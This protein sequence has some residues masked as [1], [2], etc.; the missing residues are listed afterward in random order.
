MRVFRAI[1]CNFQWWAP[2]KES[3]FDAF[4]RVKPDL[5]LGCTYSVD[6]AVAKCIARRPEMKVA[7]FASAWGEYLKDVD[8][9]K[10]PLVVTGEQEKRVVDEL[11]RTTGKPDC[12]FIHAH[13]RWLDGTMGGW[14]SLGIPYLGLLNAADVFVYLGGRKRPELACDAAF[15]GA[16]WGYKSRNIDRFL[17]PLCHLNSGLSVRIY[18]RGGWDGIANWLGP[19]SDQTASDLFASATVCPSVSEP[20]ST[21]LGWDLIERPLKTSLCGFSVSDHVEEG[22][23]LF[24]AD[25]LPMARTPEEMRDL[26]QHFAARPDD[27]LPFMVKMRKKVLSLHTYHHRVSVLLTALG[28]FDEAEAAMDNLREVL[29]E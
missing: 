10:Y 13:G 3:A 23:D 17:L 28:M 27:R 24:G 12:V 29:G 1:G 19:C 4:S 2:E 11:R 20:H 15:V 18:G 22:R 9:Q 8:L 14:G 25:E 7:L 16:R 21:D 6:R 26:V 5:F